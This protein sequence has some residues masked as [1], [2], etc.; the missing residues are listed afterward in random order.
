M[1]REN[2][3]S[4]NNNELSFIEQDFELTIMDVICD[5][6]MWR[7]SASI[8]QISRSRQAITVYAS[9]FPNQ[10]KSESAGAE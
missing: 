3:G 2:G 9:F 4:K 6:V 1:E 5:D 8:W 7:S 10:I